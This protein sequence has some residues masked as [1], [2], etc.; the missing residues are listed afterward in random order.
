MRAVPLDDSYLTETIVSGVAAWTRKT[1]ATKLLSL[2]RTVTCVCLPAELA[3]LM[4]RV[5]QPNG[6]LCLPTS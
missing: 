6:N 4:K 3:A 2:N 5:T 1:A